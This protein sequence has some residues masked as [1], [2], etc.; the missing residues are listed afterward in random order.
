MMQVLE[1][2]EGALADPATLATDPTMYAPDQERPS[3]AVVA[4]LRPLLS[5]ARMPMGAELAEPNFDFSMMSKLH[6]KWRKAEHQAQEG[7][8]ERGPQQAPEIPQQES[9][10]PGSPV[11]KRKQNWKVE[12]PSVPSSPLAAAKAGTT[13]LAAAKAGSTPL[14]AMKTQGSKREL[15]EA[16]KAVAQ[17]G[18]FSG[19]F[20]ASVSAGAPSQEERNASFLQW[21][22]S[23]VP[24]DLAQRR[25]VTFGSY[26]NSPQREQANAFGSSRFTSQREQARDPRADQGRNSS[27][28]MLAE[29]GQAAPGVPGSALP[30][31][32]PAAA[33]KA[34][35]NAAMYNRSH[36]LPF[37]FLMLSIPEPSCSV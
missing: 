10:P 16:R 20:S 14:A 23:N 27:L 15:I 37:F 1:G 17:Q 3:S 4:Q 36:P 28:E 29:D 11:S 2:I 21:R 31:L 8:L 35:L 13:P 25:S 32:D 5:V 34:M 19:S 24:Q 22:N 18:S 12:V 33:R 30:E 9:S 26:K 7:F 6:N